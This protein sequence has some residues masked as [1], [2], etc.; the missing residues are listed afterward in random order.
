MNSKVLTGALGLAVTTLLVLAMVK[1]WSLG[2]RIGQ[3]NLAPLAMAVLLPAAFVLFKR[4]GWAKDAD[5]EPK[6]DKLPSILAQEE[7]PASRKGMPVWQL[8][9]LM[10]AIML[11]GGVAIAIW[12]K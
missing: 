12:S 10:T 6:E 4:A 11:A 7:E 2:P 1:T 9:L 5:P 3:V 8:S